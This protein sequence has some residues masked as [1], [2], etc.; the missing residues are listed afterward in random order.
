MRKLIL[1]VTILLFV[2]T[3]CNKSIA[4]QSFKPRAAVAG[5]TY[6]ATAELPLIIDQD[7][8]LSNDTLWILNGKCWVTNNATLV[9]TEGARIEAVKKLSGDQASAL[10][11]TRGSKIF[12]QGTQT[13]PIVFTS[14]EASPAR[15]DW[16]GIVLLGSA[17]LNTNDQL[18]EGVNAPAVP[19]G[20][21]AYYGGGGAGNGNPHDYSGELAYIR[22]EYAGVDIAA[23]NEL[24]GLTCA[25]VGDNTYIDYIEV[26]YSADDAFEFFGGTVNARH[27]VALAPRDDAFDFDLGYTGKIQ[28][29]VSILD[30]SISYS[31][32]PNGIESDNIF[33]ASNNTP[34]TH[35]VISNMT[36]IGYNDSL[37]SHSLNLLSA[38]QFRRASHYDVRNSIFMCFPTAFLIQSSGSQAYGGNISNNIVHAYN[39]AVNPSNLTLGNG[40]AM[41]N[42]EYPNSVIQLQNPHAV[43]GPDF[44]PMPGS[45][46]LTLGTNFSGLPSFFAPVSYRGAFDVNNGSSPNVNDWL[47]GWTRFNY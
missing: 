20:V 15:G 5:K 45:P 42:G 37:H 25:G 34:F 11:I 4:Q 44:R 28:F 23:D 6:F 1:S 31:A 7:R 8:E 3:I 33:Y 19:A 29:A 39:A 10:I 38:A 43:S 9:I 24:N 22:I 26:A 47:L 36:V 41:Y 40:N 16:G 18:V 17:P 46:A 13:T 27:L 32:N 21:S 30:P 14:H 2:S 12:A 35:P